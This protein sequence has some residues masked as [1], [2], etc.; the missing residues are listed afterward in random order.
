[1][2]K[3]FTLATLVVIAFIGI[4]GVIQAPDEAPVVVREAHFVDMYVKDFTMV[5]MNEDGQP[6]YTLKAVL[7]EHY[8]DT[9]ESDVTE[10]VFN[11]NRNDSA[12]MISARRGTIDDENTWVTLNEN[13]VMLQQNTDTPLELKTSKMRFN[14]KT[15]VANSNR[16][17]DIKQGTLSLKSNGM[18]FN[19]LTGQLELLAGVNGTYVKN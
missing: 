16:Q 14:T 5:S 13:V 2:K 4:W 19:N 10:P 11:I 12:W 7:M 6:Y 1:V 18:I 17:V 3:Q 8:N 15:Q 9:G